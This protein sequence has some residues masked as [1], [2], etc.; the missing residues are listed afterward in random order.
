MASEI[1]QKV[2]VE[3]SEDEAGTVNLHFLPVKGLYVPDGK[4]EVNTAPS[5]I[6]RLAESK[7]EIERYELPVYMARLF[8]YALCAMLLVGVL[9]AALAQ[10]DITAEAKGQLVPRG[11][12]KAVQPAANGVIDSVLV[13]EGQQ[14]KAGDQL[15]LLDTTRYKEEVNRQQKELEIARTEL[16][17]ARLVRQALEE[18]VKDPGAVPSQKVEVSNLSD[19]LGN[20]YSTYATLKESEKD[21]SPG[22]TPGVTTQRADISSLE[23]RLNQLTGERSAREQSLQNRRQQFGAQQVSKEL[24]LASKIT[25]LG[26]LRQQLIKLESVADKTRQQV[27]AYK[28]V[29]EQGAVSRVDYYNA[30]KNQ[31]LDERNVIATKSQ[32]NT[33]ERS[34]EIVKSAQ[35]E[36]S[37]QAKA[38]IARQ[39]AEI[40]NLGAQIAAVQMQLRDNERKYKLAGAAFTAGLEKAKNNLEKAAV[41]VADKE[42]KLS[43]IESALKVAQR[44]Y[45]DA[46]LCAAISGTVTNIK[47][48]YKGQVVVRGETLA[49]VVPANASL[50][51]EADLP[52]KDMGFVC[53]GEKAKLK[54]DA[55]PFQDFGYVPAVVSAIEQHPRED[56]RSSSFYRVIVVPERVWVM[57]QGRKI[58]FTSGM[59]VTAEIVTRRK[60]IL[61]YFLEPIKKMRD[62]RWS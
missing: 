31:E 20:V 40:K 62:T 53:R 37:S 52:H 11:N 19:V 46:V 2:G 42:R 4:L 30:L 6:F 14:V 60:S 23:D 57:A 39:T 21:Y 27:A 56:G 18:V 5:E 1:D 25:E 61:D 50:V 55:F 3:L 15:I 59:S 34:I 47:A 24:E 9:W 43:Q 17:Q 26:N 44:N 32:I 38:E 45:D 41:D 13:S 16:E 49:T 29:F 54:F 10:V 28:L 8:V 36:L 7:C 22:S 48:R 33:L 51:V 35:V 12:V 58:T